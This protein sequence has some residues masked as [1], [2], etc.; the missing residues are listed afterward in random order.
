M[1]I[2][3]DGELFVIEGNGVKR[4]AT[5]VTCPMCNEQFLKRVKKKQKY[6]SQS[7]I[8]KARR[9]R[10][11]VVCTRCSKECERTPTQLKNSKSGLYFCSLDCK[12]KSQRLGGIPEIMPAHYGSTEGKRSY[13][14]K[15][16][17]FVCT[18]CGYDEFKS[19]VQVH[20]IDEDRN[21]N[22]MTNLILLCSNCHDALHNNC[23][24]LDS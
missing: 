16:K 20:H 14:R 11:K 5:Y 6:C 4:R 22:D 18:R 23:W 2:I 12:A 21:N 3:K 1:T 13:R 9:T 19:S 17:N 24:S 15:F 7:C 10:V 8:N